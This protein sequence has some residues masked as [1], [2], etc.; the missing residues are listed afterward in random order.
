VDFDDSQDLDEPEPE[1][2][3]GLRGKEVPAQQPR[4]NSR[5]PPRESRETKG[6]VPWTKEEES[7][8]HAAVAQYGKGKWALALKKYKFQKCRS[9][10]DLKDKWRNIVKKQGQDD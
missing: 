8:L 9:S 6:R 1:A 3:P 4:L 7:E 2:R 5:S 10:V